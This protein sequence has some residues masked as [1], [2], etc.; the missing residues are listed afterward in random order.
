MMSPE[1]RTS[2]MQA[3]AVCMSTGNTQGAMENYQRI[4]DKLRTDA[5]AY[6]GLAF[7]RA[8]RKEYPEAIK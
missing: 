7:A 3:A 5:E 4:I 8:I 1:L 6:A 2:L